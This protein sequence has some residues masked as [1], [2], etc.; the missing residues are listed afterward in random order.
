MKHPLSVLTFLPQRL[1]K[2]WAAQEMLKI[3]HSSF[4]VSHPPS[5]QSFCL[6]KRCEQEKY[7]FRCSLHIMLDILFIISK[8]SS[9]LQEHRTLISEKTL[10]AVIPFESNLT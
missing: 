5:Q 9:V 4:T 8:H 2:L 1:A 3:Q 7:Y 6:I 10:K